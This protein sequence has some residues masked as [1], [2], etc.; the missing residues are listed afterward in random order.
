[1]VYYTE[2]SNLTSV[3]ATFPSTQFP[4]AAT[5]FCQHSEK[6]DTS[7]TA[8][9]T[10]AAISYVLANRHLRTLFSRGNSD[11]AVQKNIMMSNH[12]D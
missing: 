8:I 5:H 12:N 2:I 1:L 11:Y 9:I 10:F 3:Y 4:W 7:V 6:L